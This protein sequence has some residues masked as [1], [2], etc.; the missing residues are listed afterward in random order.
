MLTYAVS[1]ASL[2]T[3]HLITKHKLFAKFIEEQLLVLLILKSNSKCTSAGTRQQRGLDL[4]ISLCSYS[5][6]F[7]SLKFCVT[8]CRV[9]VL[10][11]VLIADR[12]NECLILLIW[13]F[14]I[15]SCEY[16]S[17]KFAPLFHEL[18]H[19]C[20]LEKAKGF[21]RVLFLLQYR[22]LHNFRFI[23]F[24]FFFDC[25][26]SQLLSITSWSTSSS[27][28]NSCQRLFLIKERFS[29]SAFID[30]SP[31]ADLEGRNCCSSSSQILANRLMW[32]TLIHRFR[33]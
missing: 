8:T 17:E 27:P 24:S 29:S 1:P 25:M 23:S 3:T 28:F 6:G 4:G 10:L 19:P 32:N 14:T 15:D 20:M 33:L 31:V 22:Q 30:E 9:L 7:T 18:P 13:C 11:M 12:M 16:D 21:V 2:I 5:L 26:L